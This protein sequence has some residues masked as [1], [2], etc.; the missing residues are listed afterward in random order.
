MTPG[1][2]WK[3]NWGEAKKNLIKWW[4]R[5]GMALS[6]VAERT[7]PRLIMSK[8]SKPI[9]LEQCWIDP[10]YRCN[11]SE[12]Y[13]VTHEYLA[14]AF[15]YFDTQ[16]GPGSLGVILGV[17]PIYD[18]ETVWYKSCI[19]DPERFTGISL[20]TE[21]NSQLL[22]HIAL[23]DEGLKRSNKRYLVGI[24]DLI[25]NIDTL[26]AMRGNSQLLYDLL[27][28]P[29]WVHER[30][31]EINQAYFTVFNMMF[32][33]VQDE[34]G[35]NA[36]AAFNIWGPGKTA[37][38]QCD[39]S[40]MIS[41][42]MFQEFVVPYLSAQ[43]KWLDYSLY[44]L[45]G[46]TAL[47]HLDKL[48]EVENLNAIEWTPQAG[49]PGGGSQEWYNLYKRIKRGGKGI[50]AIGVK[51]DELIPLIDAIGPEGLFILLDEPAMGLSEAEELVKKVE[52]Y[53]P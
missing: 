44:H 51:A 17:K 11:A 35:G 16:I 40:A 12:Y 21:G 39:F 34:D 25:E 36:F 24:P 48:L 30:L 6:I 3:D 18:V 29:G 10:I 37:K 41:P 4:N 8:P 53:Y 42:H 47:H 45:D 20:T 15:P 2:L 52:P 46:T 1:V 43:C 38:L 22:A 28:R 32:E 31:A 9:N 7:S 13:M 26:A 5:E 23:I 49:R 14:E 33:K 19:D 50:Q 27:E